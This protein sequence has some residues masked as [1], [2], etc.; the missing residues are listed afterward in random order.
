MSQ[1]EEIYEEL[2]GRTDTDPEIEEELCTRI[3]EIE[4]QGGVAEPLLKGDWILVAILIAVGTFLPILYYA[5]QY[6]ITG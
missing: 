1:Y 2:K 5:F 3:A 4:T 6:G